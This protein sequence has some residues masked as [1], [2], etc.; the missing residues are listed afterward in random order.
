MSWQH[1][2]GGANGLISFC[3]YRIIEEAKEPDPAVRKENFSRV[4]K[5]SHEIAR[6]FPVLL[7]IEACP[8][9]AY[10]ADLLAC[11]AWVKDGELYLLA[12]NLTDKP[13]EAEVSVAGGPWRMVGCEVGEPATMADD[14]KVHL[15]LPPIGVSLV[16][17]RNR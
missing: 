5:V 17:L 16:R 1:I 11:R 10:Q 13:L 4:C 14:G 7:S 15:S 8:K 9:I 3:F 2:A 12:C 6:M